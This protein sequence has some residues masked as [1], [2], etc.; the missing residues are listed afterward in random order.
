MNQTYHDLIG[1]DCVYS[2]LKFWPK[3]DH[4]TVYVEDMIL[5]H[6]DR[7]KQISFANLDADYQKFQDDP[8]CNQSEKK[9]AKKAFQ[10]FCK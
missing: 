6:D 9:F 10:C 7:V 1:R 2:F 4:L 3:K 8:D 5:E